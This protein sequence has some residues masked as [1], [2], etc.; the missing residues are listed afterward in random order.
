MTRSAMTYNKR[1][2]IILQIVASTT[3]SFNKSTARLFTPWKDR[4]RYLCPLLVLLNI[5]CFFIF[6]SLFFSFPLSSNSKTYYIFG[7]GSLMNK[8]S[9]RSTGITGHGIPVR[10]AHMKRAWNYHVDQVHHANIKRAPCTA[11]G[12]QFDF[13]NPDSTVNGVLFQLPLNELAKFD[14][15]EA[16]YERHQVDHEHITILHDADVLQLDDNAVVYV[17]VVPQDIALSLSDNSR[18]LK[19]SYIDL[20]ISGCFE[21]N[22][23]EFA[24]ECI[25][26]TDGWNAVYLNDRHQPY[27]AKDMIGAAMQQEID[28]LL[29]TELTVSKGG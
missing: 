27:A 29:Q 6:L 12:V 11:V 26:T 24:L 23:Y 25:R 28:Q 1:E 5:C 17:Y 16:R 20:F 10:V 4:Y 19:Q 18:I 2:N 15:R 14:G 22:G 8:A 13:T 21:V 7:Y 3:Q 9:R